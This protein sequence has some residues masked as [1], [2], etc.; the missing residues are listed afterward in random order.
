MRDTKSAELK[1][2]G[3]PY[4]NDINILFR[5]IR[6]RNRDVSNRL[7]IHPMEGADGETD[8]GPGK[9]TYRRYD[10]F[11]KGGSGLI[12]FE[13]VAVTQESK[14]NPRQLYITEKNLDDYKYLIR[15]ININ[16]IRNPFLKTEVPVIMQLT[17]SG[18][19]SNPDGKANP[20]IACH[21]PILNDRMN[22]SDDY[23]VLSDS[24]LER[25]EDEYV[26][27]ALLAQ[28]AGFDGIDI[29]SC[30][31]YL[32]SELLGAYTRKGYYGSSFEGRTRFLYNIVRKIKD[33]VNKDFIVGCRLN[34]YDGIEYPYGFGVDKK[35]CLRCDF[36]EPLEVIRDLCK[37]DVD[38]FNI[39]MGTPYYNPHVNRPF[40]KGEY[41]PEEHYMKGVERLING[42]G[43]MQT[44]FPDKTMVAT[45]LSVLKSEFPFIAS[46]IVEKGLAKMVGFG[47]QA[48]AYPDFANDLIKFG[49]IDDSKSCIACGKCTELMRNGLPSGCVVRDT[50]VYSNLYVDIKKG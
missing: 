34:V 23:P 4:S 27:S 9:L 3:I 7:V 15:Q 16:S 21:N 46:G 24:D 33:R 19:F 20:I 17:H 25:L 18:R 36:A 48:F 11:S 41:K 42:V 8:G 28:E 32:I 47:R 31:R 29:K 22:L 10:R 39:T 12:W 30:H 1:N 38:I 2:L 45:G 5:K 13:A 14:A 50:Q 37:M 6:I 44:H 35:D 43:E 49:K 40:L 26:R